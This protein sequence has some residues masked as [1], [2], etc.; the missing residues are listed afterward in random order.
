[1]NND[2]NNTNTNASDSEK[3]KCKDLAKEYF[4]I[5]Q[6][7]GGSSEVRIVEHDKLYVPEKEESVGSIIKT[8]ACT[9]RKDYHHLDSNEKA[10]VSLGLNSILDLSHTYPDAQ[11]TLFNNRQWLH[12]Q[13][14]NRPKKYVSEEYAYISNIIQPIFKAYN[15][16]KTSDQNWTAIY[17]QAKKLAEQNDPEIDISKKDISFCIHVMLQILMVIKHESGL[18]SDTVDSSEWDYIVKF[19]GPIT[20][21][22]FY[23]SGLRL[24]WGDTHLTMHDT[25]GDIVLKVDL[26]IIHESIKQRYNVENEVGVAEAAEENPGKVK[27]HSDRCKVLIESKAIVDRFILDGCNI[28][29]VDSLQICGM[30][31]YFIK[32]ELRDHGLYTGTQHYHSVVDASLNSLDKYMDLAMNLLCFRDRCIQIHNIYENHLASCRGQQKSAK[33]SAPRPI[34]DDISSKQT[35]IR[36]TWNPPRTTKTPPPP[37]PSNLCSQEQ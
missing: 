21:R 35:W 11:S 36:G 3:G 26:R 6:H 13:R 8:K 9:L 31:I 28:D 4:F 17:I 18:F 10:I 30:E 7:Q 19:W 24:K 2:K 16:A 14:T 23:F 5:K 25:I 15:P 22:L 27:F 20:Q 33:R 29:N 1:M 32:L 37:E 12:L 34:D